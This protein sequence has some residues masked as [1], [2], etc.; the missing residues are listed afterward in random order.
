MNDVMPQ[1]TKLVDELGQSGGIGLPEMAQAFYGGDLVLPPRNPKRAVANVNFVVRRDGVVNIPENPGGGTISGGSDADVALMAVLR[2][3]HGATAVGSETL[4]AEPEH[5]WTPRFI[6]PGFADMLEKWRTDQGLVK[7]P[8]NVIISRSGKVRAA[9]GSK[10]PLG[11]HYPVFNQEDVLA[12]VITTPDGE[13]VLREAG[14]TSVTS[15]PGKKDFEV[16]ILEVLKNEHGVNY[17]LVEGGPTVNGALHTKGLVSDDFLTL[18]PGMA[19]F[20]PDSGRSTLMMGHEFPADALPMPDL[21][22]VHRSG[23]HL[24]VRERY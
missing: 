22:T 14:H 13:R 23:K 15:V 2:A 21:L 7:N 17:V 4:A 9:D 1:L 10:Q 8:L 20:T 11:T 19:G 16:E 6:Y 3:V 12:V 24:M 18:A 5:L